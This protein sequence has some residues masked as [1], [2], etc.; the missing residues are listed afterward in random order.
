VRSQYYMLVWMGR[1]CEIPTKSLLYDQK[2]DKQTFC[3]EDT[4]SS[5]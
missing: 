1:G 4:V 3:N 5:D 2:Q